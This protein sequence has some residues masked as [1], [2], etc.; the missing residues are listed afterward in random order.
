VVSYP[1]KGKRVE[2]D[3]R[4]KLGADLL[5]KYNKGKSIRELAATTGRSYGFVHRLLGESGADLRPRGGN[6]RRG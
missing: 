4:D 1:K 6:N 5:K 3:Q 2:G